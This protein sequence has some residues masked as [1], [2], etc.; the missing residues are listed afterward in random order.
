[1]SGDLSFFPLSTEAIESLGAE[2]RKAAVAALNGTAAAAVRAAYPASTLKTMGAFFSGPGLAIDVA[3]SLDNVGTGQVIADPSVGTGDLILA[4][5]RRLPLGEDLVST[6]KAWSRTLVGFDTESAFVQIARRRLT[7]LAALRWAASSGS[8]FFKVLDHLNS[9]GEDGEE[10]FHRI[11]VGDGL[12]LLQQEHDV[13]GIMMNPPFGRVA[14]RKVTWAGGSVSLAAV[15]LDSVLGSLSPG[16][17]IVAVL[18]DVVRSGSRYHRLRKWVGQRAEV[19]DISPL[20]RFSREADVDVFKLTLLIKRRPGLQT[21]P[22]WSK[23][24]VPQA[25]EV[26]GDIASVSVGPVVPHRHQEAGPSLAFLTATALTRGKKRQASSLARRQFQGTV[27]RPPFVAIRRTSR[28]SERGRAQ[29]TIVVG[30]QNVAVE[31]HVIVVVP[32]KRTILAC[33]RVAKALG[34]DA[35]GAWLDQRIRCR[36]LTVSSVKEIPVWSD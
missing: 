26:I 31:N 10:K 29:A 24:E 33:E 19:I 16:S 27:F 22:D 3:K 9:I 25:R 18:P 34:L 32:K 35:T 6:I 20:G 21:S 30:S 7:L 1:M 12:Q 13:R 15:F 36:H 14:D 4:R 17:S 2:S 8:S 28:P 23:P 11:R 5:A